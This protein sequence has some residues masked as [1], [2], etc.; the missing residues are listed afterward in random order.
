[1]SGSR[2]QDSH[3]SVLEG[4]K[5]LDFGRYIAGPF[6]AALLGDF[7]ADVIRVDRIGGNEDRF[8]L[9][10][11]AQGEGAQFPRPRSASH[12]AQEQKTALEAS[13]RS[14]SS[15]ARW[16][17]DRQDYLISTAME[18]RPSG[19]GTAR[20]RRKELTDMAFQLSATS[21]HL[22]AAASRRAVVELL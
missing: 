1:M 5:V 11:T 4:V 3:V 22:Q 13:K 2:L 21:G 16:A 8:I 9:P 20:P 15:H 14:A 19:P 17:C 6:C 7:G 10:V 18:A 12:R